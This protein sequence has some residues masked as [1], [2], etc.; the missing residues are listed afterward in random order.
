MIPRPFY[1]SQPSIAISRIRQVS[2]PANECAK[3]TAKCLR[4]RFC[5]LPSISEVFVLPVFVLPVFVLPVFVLPVFVLPV[6]VLPV[7]VLWSC[8]EC[9]VEDSLDLRKRSTTPNQ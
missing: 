5:E 2:C 7:F 4:N 6:F 1:P 9:R 8:F 3:R